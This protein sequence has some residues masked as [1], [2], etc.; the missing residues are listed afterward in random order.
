[1]PNQWDDLIEG[2]GQGLGAVIEGYNQMQNNKLASE[3]YTTALKGIKKTLEE[4]QM[5]EQTNDQSKLQEINTMINGQPPATEENTAG[6]TDLKITSTPADVNKGT[7]PKYTV[8]KKPLTMQDLYMQVSDASVRLGQLGERGK[9]K[10][11]QLAGYLD[12]ALKDKDT[13]IVKVGTDFYT[14]KTGDVMGSLNKL[15][16]P[17]E[18]KASKINVVWGEPEY[19]EENGEYYRSYPIEDA[20]GQVLPERHKQKITPEEYQKWQRSLQEKQPTGRGRSGRGSTSQKKTNFDYKDDALMT[21][22]KQMASIL[23]EVNAMGGLDKV[24]ELAGTFDKNAMSLLE[25]Y[26]RQTQLVSSYGV[27]PISSAEAF[28]S[29]NSQE[30]FM[31]SNEDRQSYIADINSIVG[32]MLN[33]A[34]WEAYVNSPPASNGQFAN[35]WDE[36]FWRLVDELEADGVPNDIIDRYVKRPYDNWR[37]NEGFAEPINP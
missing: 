14:Y 16:S 10:A 17:D 18:V 30:D 24:E 5:Q 37:K 36:D 25:K 12:I 21:E 28:E 27:D 2:A 15:Y 6:I 22:S 33:P 26:D 4:Y 34:N 3:V 32:G 7:A 20:T 19:I 9:L 1:M 31:E 23:R 13:K 35:K 11:E 8:T 29:S